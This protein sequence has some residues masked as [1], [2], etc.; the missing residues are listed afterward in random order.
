MHLTSVSR[1]GRTSPLKGIALAL[2]LCVVLAAGMISPVTAA[3]P[4]AWTLTNK[5]TGQSACEI[6]IDHEGEPTADEIRAAC[7]E[8]IFIGWQNGEYL[9]ARS[10]PALQTVTAQHSWL[11]TPQTSAGLQTNRPLTY[12]AGKL[13]AA[14]YVDVSKCDGGALLENGYASP[15]GLEAARPYVFV[16]QN[17]FDEFIYQSAGRENIPAFLLKN[18]LMQESQMWPQASTHIPPEYGIGQLTENGADTLL[19]W[20]VPFFRGACDEFLAVEKCKKEYLDLESSQRAY[21]R[22]SSLILVR[23]DCATCVNGI[24]LEVAERSITVFAAALRANFNQVDQIVKNLTGKAAIKQMEWQEVWKLAAA[25]YH[26]GPGCTSSAMRITL[27][28]RQALRWK[29]ISKNYQAGCESAVDYVEHLITTD[30]SAAFPSAQAAESAARIMNGLPAASSQAGGGES[31]AVQPQRDIASLLKAPHTDNQI[32]VR[33][34]PLK[35]LETIQAIRGLNTAIEFVDPVG[36]LLVTAQPA[37]FEAVLTALQTLDGVESAD[38][39]YLVHIAGAP[40]DPEFPFQS[41]LSG[42]QVPQAWDVLPSMMSQVLVAVLDTGVED[43]H[44]DLTDAIWQNPGEMGLDSNGADKRSNQADDDLNGYV[45]DWR[46]WDMVSNDNQAQDDNGHGTH[47]AGIIAARSNNNLGVAGIAPNARILPVKVLDAGGQSDHI[48]VARGIIYA[49]DMGARI[50]NLGLGGDGTSALLNNAVDYALAHNVIVIAA[51]G[52][53]SDASVQYPASYTGVVAVGAVDES[54]THASFSTTGAYIGITAPGVNIPSTFPGGVYSRASGTSMASAHVSGVAALLAGQPE[55]SDP[56]FLIASI[57]DQALDAG[58]PGR[59]PLY[60]AGLLQTMNV[61]ISAGIGEPPSVPDV[62]PG[63]DAAPQ[64]GMSG[65][66]ISSYEL[67][68]GSTVYQSPL[69]GEDVTADLAAD[70]ISAPLPIGFDF[71]YM[72]GRY[73]EIYASANGWLSF[74]DP[75]AASLPINDLDNHTASPA[76]DAARPFLAPLWDDL[77]SDADSSFSYRVLGTAPDRQFVF[78]WWNVISGSGRISVRAALNEST[79]RVDFMYH[80]N[81][82]GSIDGASAGITGKLSGSYLSLQSLGG[83]PEWSSAF[84]T[85]NLSAQPASGAGYSFSP[86]LV[87]LAAPEGLLVSGIS[88]NSITLNWMD[89]SEGEDGFNIFNSSDGIHFDYFGQAP[90]NETQFQAAGLA[91]SSALYWQ[92]AAVSEGNASSSE[93]VSAPDGLSFSKVEADSVTLTWTDRSDN[94]TGFII[95]NSTDAINFT[96]LAKTIANANTY[97]AS[98]LQPDM[99]YTWR[100]QALTANSLSAA[101]VGEVQTGSNTLPEAQIISPVTDGSELTFIQG[102]EII[103]NG[104]GTDVEDGNIS[105]KLEW[106]SSIDGPIG[107]GPAFAR[108]DLGL[109]AHTITLSAVDAFNG[110]ARATLDIV[111]ANAD[112][113]TPPVLAINSPATDTTYVQG[114]SINFAG[115]AADTQDG[116]IS[117]SIVWTSN[118]DGTLGTGA[119]LSI[120]SLSLGTHR[121]TALVTDSGSLTSTTSIRV[122]ITNANG[123]A[124]PQVTIVSPTGGSTVFSNSS[125]FFNATALIP[126]NGDLSGLL[127]WKDGA[128]TIGNGA[129]FSLNGL[130][131]GVHTITAS[132]VDALGNTGL[133]TITLTVRAANESPHGGFTANTDKCAACHRTHTAQGTSLKASPLSGNAYCLEC[134]G[135]SGAD[136]ISTH[137]NKDWGGPSIEKPTPPSFELLCTQCHDPHGTS[138]LFAIKTQVLVTSNGSV[139]SGPVLFTATTGANS[140][141]DGVS[142]NASRICVTCHVNASNPGFPMKNHVGGA[143]HAGGVD[144]S[145][146]DCTTCHRHSADGT[147][148]TSDGFMASCR[149]CHSST[150]DLNQGSPRRKIVGATGGDFT[151]TSHHVSGSDA[152]TDGDCV[153][154]HE[155]SRHTLGKV[156]LLDVDTPATVYELDYALNAVDDP[157]DYE[158]FC[159]SCHDGDGQAGDMVPFSD[160]QIVPSLNESG[161]TAGIHNTPLSTFGGSCLDCHD[162]GHGSNKVKLLYPWDVAAADPDPAAPTV[163]PNRQEERFCYYCHTAAGPGTNVQTA[164][165]AYTNTATSF[166]KHDVSTT[167]GP[168]QADEVLGSLFG[169]SN[170]HVECGDCHSPHVDSSGTASAPSVKPQNKGAS[171]VVPVFNGVGTPIRFNFLTQITDESQICMKCHSSYTTLPTYLPDGWG[172]TVNNGCTR[173]IVAN[174]L[175]KL[176]SA[177]VSQIKDTRDMA[178]AFNPSNPSYHPLL[179]V[180]KNTSMPAGGFVTGWTINSR[181]YCSDCHTNATPATGGEGTHGSPLLHM[182]DGSAAGNA[183]YSTALTTSGNDPVV[184]NT[185][186]CFKCH[187]YATYVTS[188]ATTNTRFQDGSNLHS[189]HMSGGL[190]QATCY[191]C[192]N[193]HGSQQDHLINFDVSVVTP[194]TGRNSLTAFTPSATG[195]TCALACH[196]KG[197]NETYP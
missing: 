20:N 163:D 172:C 146:Q 129:S 34:D 185:E 110:T 118:V 179:A 8:V 149:A 89:L 145:G 9:L 62:I 54:Y 192:H 61:L 103:F 141:D 21:L 69:G 66:L 55:F 174:G 50:I 47:L 49:T 36:V 123:Y 169:G 106:A 43:T 154:C 94:E 48:K 157:A 125:L 168:H 28:S 14:G 95:L 1:R 85:E 153:V 19:M 58:E 156:R 189:E 135:D 99:K 159:I 56:D 7:G 25:N 82:P 86:V 161:W 33:V 164:F 160:S 196:G 132:V 42:I 27:K 39:N 122:T 178:E 152:V 80:P 112:G 155:M 57:F 15:C 102:E 142:A 136:A 175:R 77:A 166:Y 29:N 171:G 10:E 170:R 120:S 18:L 111:I 107:S 75:G 190:T 193:S 158:N 45:D 3:G 177:S 37:D 35:R 128:T 197:H 181:V 144:Y 93:L 83:C 140:H 12:L 22:G 116:D 5:Q 6:S 176:T 87:P 187:D 13:I 73:S 51:G 105:G 41:G 63:G 182:L 46:G 26:A 121:I 44:P 4:F 76:N 67:S 131:V 91:D 108:R 30:D 119:S 64:T 11:D 150:Q 127:V 38:P 100:V 194:N 90:A 53:T 92:V 162:S 70:E 186:I 84:E 167:N 117:T 124:P 72:G 113:N 137:S 134:H 59:D 74:N 88:Q 68:C 109:G 183:N 81:Q 133:D 78:E 114:T 126:T 165:S 16:W 115:T 139:T 71:W 130:S 17:R 188:A 97:T 184:P 151:R 79:G 40:N 191:T 96:P 23:A 143:S 148:A 32:V 31:A 2:I 138:N 24:D 52:N 60:G 98:G 195:G 173:T 104:M 101:A 147:A 65:S 180:G